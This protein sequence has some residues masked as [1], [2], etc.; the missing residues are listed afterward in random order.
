MK[1]LDLEQIIFEI[2]DEANLI[3]RKEDGLIY[4]IQDI[5]SIQLIS[6]IVEIEDKLDIEIP[7]TYLVSDILNDFDHLVQVIEE[8]ILKKNE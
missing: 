2:L 7:D 4:I 3:D 5:D 8:I 1:R 6:V